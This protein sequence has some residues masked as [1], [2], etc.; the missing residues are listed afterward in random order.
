[1][2]NTPT[3]IFTIAEEE[4]KINVEYKNTDRIGVF[5]GEKS[6]GKSTLINLLKGA[7]KEEVPKATYAMEYSFVKRTTNNRKEVVHF[8][9]LGGGKELAE[10]VPVPLT[11]ETYKN[12]VY[13]ILVDLSEPSTLM[14]SLEYWLRKVREAA[15]NICKSTGTSPNRSDNY[16]KTAA[17]LE[18]HDD[19]NKV[20][21]IG[22]PT[23][24]IGTKYDQF[25]EFDPENRK[26]ITRMIRYISHLNGCSLFFSSIANQ[27]HSLQIRGLLNNYLFSST[28]PNLSQK[29]YAKP[30]FLTF[31]A[32]SFDSMGIPTSGNMSA[33]DV[34][35]KMSRDYF[36]IDKNQS[37]KKNTVP[38]D[39]AKY[40]ETKID[41]T[42]LEKDHEMERAH[43]ANVGESPV[44]N[45]LRTG[46][47]SNDGSTSDILRKSP[48]STFDKSGTFGGPSENVRPTVKKMRPVVNRPGSNA[49]I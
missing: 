17:T 37:E 16:L 6:C 28:M 33:Y 19:R 36:P 34:L 32:D 21:P 3:D 48:S 22:V 15:D 27:K 5:L 4:E 13:I 20:Q 2:A 39:F 25:E 45:D 35:K 31:G 7:Q 23:I 14:E 49:N 30:L 47:A 18:Q 44:S 11:K 42:K 43:R 40:P 10:L 12:I 1:M 38:L 26:W 41:S 46:Y 8:Y 29:D 9:E 24:I